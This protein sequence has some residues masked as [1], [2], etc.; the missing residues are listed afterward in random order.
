VAKPVGGNKKR[1]N[2]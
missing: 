2:Y 1:S